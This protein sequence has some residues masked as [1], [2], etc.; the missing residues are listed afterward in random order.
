MYARFDD[1]LAQNEKQKKNSEKKKVKKEKKSEAVVNSKK[2]SNKDMKE[3]YNDVA[4]QV[5]LFGFE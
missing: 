1:L 5:G 4:K 2:V 3:S